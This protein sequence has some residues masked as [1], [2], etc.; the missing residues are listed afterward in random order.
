MVTGEGQCTVQTLAREHYISP[1][2]GEGEERL[3][4]WRC[5]CV[6]NSPSDMKECIAAFP[7]RSRYQS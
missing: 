2:Q 1:G 3:S 5:L 6:K 7:P 4:N